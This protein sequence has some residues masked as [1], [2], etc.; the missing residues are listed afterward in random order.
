MAFS[1]FRPDF[2]IDQ[3][4]DR[5]EQVPASEIMTTLDQIKSDTFIRLWVSGEDDLG[6]PRRFMAVIKLP[7]GDDVASRLNETGLQLF[8]SSQG[9]E[10]DVVEIGSA[11]SQAGLDVFQVLE[12]M[13]VPNPQPPKQL[14][15][16]PA[17]GLILFVA[18]S[19]RRR[20]LK[21]KRS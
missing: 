19:Q 21:L 7:Q 11:A 10:V 20:K 2:W 6:D 3:V 1:L 9:L 18:I 16:I 4:V 5:Y 14:I 15:Y 17:F 13:E 12:G 8:Q